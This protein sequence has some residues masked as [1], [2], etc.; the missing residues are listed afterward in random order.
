MTLSEESRKLFAGTSVVCVRLHVK[1]LVH[2]FTLICNM[3]M[4]EVFKFLV[5]R[6]F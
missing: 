4:H 5:E 3:C 6:V 2:K 1:V